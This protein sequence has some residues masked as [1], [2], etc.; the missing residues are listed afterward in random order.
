NQ[1]ITQGQAIK[2]LQQLVEILK[3][4]H[5][6]HYF[7]RD[8]KP[9]NIMLKPDGQLVLI[10][11]GAVREVTPTFLHKKQ[12]NW[13]GTKIGT[14]GYT[15]PEQ[16]R[17]LAVPQSDFF[18]LGRTF[19]YLLTGQEPIDF[20]ED[21]DTYELQQNWRESVP[22]MGELLG[23]LIDDLILP[24]VA[25]RPQN[26]DIILQRIDEIL[27]KTDVVFQ[28]VESYI[29][30]SFSRLPNYLKFVVEPIKKHH[31]QLFAKQIRTPKIA[32]YGRSGSGK[33]SVLNAI[34]GKRVAEVGVAGPVTARPQSY[35]YEKNDWKLTFVDTRGVGDSVDD[36]AISEA[37]EYI[38]QEKV[39][40]FLF[41]IPAGEHSYI[42]KDAQFLML[43]KEEHY[44]AHKVE[45]PIIL[46][47]NKIDEIAHPYEWNPNPPYNLNWESEEL[48]KEPN[49]PR[50]AKELNI[51]DAIKHK[52]NEYQ[53]ITYQ[54][55][56]PV[57]AYWDKMIDMRYNI[58]VLIER[59]YDNIPESAQISFAGATAV[60][61]V[62]KLVA[63]SLTTTAALL[64]GSSCLIP[65]PGIDILA[66][67][68]I[69]VY[70]VDIIAGIGSSDRDSQPSATDFIS[71][72]LSVTGGAAITFVIKQ[73]CSII[74]GANL[75][76]NA[77]AAAAVGTMTMALGSAAEAYFIDGLSME[78]VREKFEEE[79]KRV[80]PELEKTFVQS[81]EQNY[82]INE[83]HIPPF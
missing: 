81:S 7:H 30:S 41:V 5:A 59:I 40:I 71:N 33:S 60:N 45:L 44:K 1:P 6:Q 8:I 32:L 58:E 28:K 80:K 10:D 25:K 48:L 31:L 76:A 64:A 42:A 27:I 36:A 13:S 11:F 82:G 72:L 73:V 16:H 53:N 18:S 65:V 63:S 51:I 56:V 49:S 37:I 26:A 35:S 74:P 20:D 83:M 23:D 70:L 14:V 17:G 47:I 57:C 38:V 9:S 12:Q 77:S 43:L 78:E 62:Q 67:G 68:A 55:V 54:S 69:Q 39:D 22:E 21:L 52:L 29:E 75:V 3:E 61:S 46:V 15:P 66:V 24:S 2:W 4:V 19:I 34:L 79:K 50:E